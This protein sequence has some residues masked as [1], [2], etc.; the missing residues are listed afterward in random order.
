MC[1]SKMAA[2]MDMHA[3]SSI[4][5]KLV[6]VASECAC[7]KRPPELTCTFVRNLVDRDVHE[8]TCAIHPALGRAFGN[9][10]SYSE[11]ARLKR[12][13]EWTCACSYGI[14]KTKMCLR[15]R[16]TCGAWWNIRY[17]A[18][19][20]TCLKRPSEWTYA[21]FSAVMQVALTVLVCFSSSRYIS[22]STPSHTKLQQPGRDRPPR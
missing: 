9:V 13:L 19:D 4:R 8:G 21:S 15:G 11:C 12:P 17:R 6:G 3:W 1:M 18:S 10:A 20:C 7:L 5:S 14:P 2:G 16:D 22:Q